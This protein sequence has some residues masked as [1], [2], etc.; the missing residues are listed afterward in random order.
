VHDIQIP[1]KFQT[2][3]HYVL[4]YVFNVL[5]IR[6]HNRRLSVRIEKAIDK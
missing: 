6:L 4:Q 3:G 2:H 5:A 1:Q